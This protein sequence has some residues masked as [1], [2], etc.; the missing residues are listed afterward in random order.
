MQYVSM[1]TGSYSTCVQNIEKYY[2]PQLMK[3]LLQSPE[4]PVL[5]HC[6][7]GADTTGTL[8]ILIKGLLGVSWE[9]LM[10]DYEFTSFSQF[11]VR[12]RTSQDIMGLQKTLSEYGD[13]DDS[14]EQCVENLF[15]AGGVAEKQIRQLRELLLET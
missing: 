9:N 7:G 8:V 3:I 15:L 13:P 14:I 12:T 4:N 6:W 10:I 2:A 11:G 5:I 1:P